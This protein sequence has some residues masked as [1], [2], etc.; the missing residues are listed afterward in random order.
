MRKNIVIESL[1]L[2]SFALFGCSK[3]AADA[4]D[5]NPD[6]DKYAELVSAC[7]EWKAGGG[8]SATGGQ[9][10]T[11]VYH[12]TTL[13]DGSK[14]DLTPGTLRYALMQT[15][16]RIIVFDVAGVIAL[17]SDLD[18]CPIEHQ[19]CASGRFVYLRT[20]GSGTGN[21]FG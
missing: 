9:G 3:N 17:A 8:I 4:P 19:E 6:I 13:E 1:L 2:L 18:M 10:T 7:S 14:V 20:I 16:K 15:G 21:L 5:T 11:T 12:I